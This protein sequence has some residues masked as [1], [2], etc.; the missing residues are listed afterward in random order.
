MR[1]LNKNKKTDDEIKQEKTER[2][3][4]QVNDWTAYYRGNIHRFANDFLNV[5]LHLFQQILI[6][7]MSVS[8]E[9]V[10]VAS[11]GLGKS[12]LIAVFVCCWAIL[13][14]NV[15][16]NIAS[17]TLTQAT[18]IL[19]K[20]EGLMNN[21]SLLF[22]EIEG[23]KI[24][25][26]NNPEVK[27][28]NNSVIRAVASNDNARSFRGN[29]NIYDEYPIMKKDII[30]T[31]L[32]KFLTGVRDVG[33]KDKAEYK[34]SKYIETNKR[35][36]LGSAWFKSMWGYVTFKSA[37][38]KMLSGFKNVFVCDIPYEIA[39]MEGIIQKQT[40]INE[41]QKPDFDQ[42]VF[43]MEYG[44]KWFGSKDSEF[45]SLES[46]LPQRILDDPLPSLVDVLNEREFVDKLGFLDYR[47]LSCDVALMASTK[48]KKNDASFITI[49]DAIKQKN[50]RFKA[51]YRMMDTDEG[52]KTEELGLKVMRYFYKYK[53]DY[54]VLDCNGNGL[55][56][57]DYVC[58]EHKD[59]DTG[60]I[61]P[62]IQ[63][64]NDPTMAERCRVPNAKKK[65]YSVKASATF[66]DL[67]A[68]RFRTGFENGAI[69]LL[70]DSR[71]Y[72]SADSNEMES[73]SL[74]IRKRMPFVETDL[75]INEIIHLVYEI[76]NNKFKITEVA[77]KRKD[78]YSSMS[79]AYYLIKELESEK[80]NETNRS[81]A[82]I[83]SRY[84]R[85]PKLEH[86]LFN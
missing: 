26:N 67:A 10:F 81:S 45:F 74:R 54:L 64:Y 22:N 58:S 78:K 2:F 68:K 80:V 60:E 76:V 48:K 83:F 29:I 21:S 6:Y 33:F 62:A 27:F 85:A 47:I 63:C 12:F 14:P 30:D 40:V 55:G 34:G 50:K 42:S 57:Y 44:G 11:R 82:D 5:K 66:N 23:G 38:K 51:K 32:D 18:N 7:E 79:Y 72:D 17:A 71:N 41:F 1:A 53:C 56:V 65:L 20:I 16:I 28:K 36:Y 49:V 3:R 86:G 24:K 77:G 84:S 70:I 75:A 8:D 31:V 39:I 46:I 37:V 52:L 4:Q 61:Y 35:I 59:P 25:T 15:E 13:Y 43:D 69:E 9:F 19:K 73:E